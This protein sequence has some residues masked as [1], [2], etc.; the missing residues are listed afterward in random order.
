MKVSVMK[1]NMPCL[2]KIY[3][4]KLLRNPD[5]ESKPYSLYSVVNFFVEFVIKS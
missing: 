3:C 1:E 5:N 4:E 2:V